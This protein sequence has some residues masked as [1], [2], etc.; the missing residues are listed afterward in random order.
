[1]SGG[2]ITPRQRAL[3]YVPYSFG[4]LFVVLAVIDGGFCSRL[5]VFLESIRKPDLGFPESI[6][7]RAVAS[8]LRRVHDEFSGAA[9][10]LQ[11]FKAKFS[12]SDSDGGWGKWSEIALVNN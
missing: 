1:M 12:D 5:I 4:L 10:P 2:A 7:S 9:L 6:N 11:P 3:N 8:Y